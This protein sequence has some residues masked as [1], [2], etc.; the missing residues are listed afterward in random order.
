LENL[1]CFGEINGWS[2]CLW[3][4]ED[5]D[6]GNSGLVKSEIG[7]IFIKN[8]RNA[9]KKCAILELKSPILGMIVKE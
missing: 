9:K 5:R 4:H 1:F 7:K 6:I 2:S 8:I 3:D